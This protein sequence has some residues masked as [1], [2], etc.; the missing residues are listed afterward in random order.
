[1][2]DIHE[3]YDCITDVAITT[4]EAIESVKRAEMKVRE[5][6][7]SINKLK[8]NGD[9]TITFISTVTT[10]DA[11][12]NLLFLQLYI[13]QIFGLVDMPEFQEFLELPSIYLVDPSEEEF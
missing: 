8:R 5:A 1:M 2:N 13:S 11:H 10:K 3:Y 7:V 9:T 4:K 12:R 6:L